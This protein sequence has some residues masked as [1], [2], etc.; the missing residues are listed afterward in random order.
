MCHA[1]RKALTDQI[2][3]SVFTQSDSGVSP[4]RPALPGTRVQKACLPHILI[5]FVWNLNVGVNL[6]S[7]AISVVGVLTW[8]FLTIMLKLQSEIRAY[9]I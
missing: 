7:R 9:P 4:V 5:F 2:K 3:E 1:S 8:L 6:T